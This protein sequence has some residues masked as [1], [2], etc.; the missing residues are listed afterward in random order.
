MNNISHLY[1]QCYRIF[2]FLSH[3]IMNIYNNEVEWKKKSIQLLLFYSLFTVSMCLYVVWSDWNTFYA[4]KSL[5]LCEF[6]SMRLNCRTKC[7]T[8]REKIKDSL[9]GKW[10]YGTFAERDCM[11]NRIIWFNY[12]LRF[13]Y[14]Y[15]S[16]IE[17]RR[18][19]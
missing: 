14:L 12:Y 17:K 1:I 13:V 9:T 8:E 6:L 2:F 4:Y 7:N 3:L 10:S 19:S 11:Y 15:C 16:H 5:C 18:E